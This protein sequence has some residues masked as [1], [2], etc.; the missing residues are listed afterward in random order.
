MDDEKKVEMIHF[1][2]SVGGNKQDSKEKVLFSSKLSD[3]R[4]KVLTANDKR[5]IIQCIG[6]VVT[7]WGNHCVGYGTGTVFKYDRDRNYCY[8]I[9]C[10]HNVVEEDDNKAVKPSGIF[11][12]RIETL[13]DGFKINET[14]QIYD[15]QYH[16]EYLFKDQCHNDIAVLLFSDTDGF[17]QK[18][19]DFSKINL[20]SSDKIPSEFI[21]NYGLYGY[22]FVTNNNVNNTNSTQKT[23]NVSGLVGYLFAQNN[24]NNNSTKQTKIISGQLYGMETKSFFYNKTNNIKMYVEQN[25]NNTMFFYNAIDT[26]GGQ[27]GSSIF[28]S[29]RDRISNCI[30]YGIVGIHTGGSVIKEKNWGVSVNNKKIEWV[31]KIVNDIFKQYTYTHF[32]LNETINIANNLL[33]TCDMKRCD[34]IYIR[35]T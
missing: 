11:F 13:D 12:E 9:T 7:L 2:S 24:N 19:I 14:Y 32:D 26:Q 23:N 4:Q 35:K 16:K 27:S 15:H 6:R 18:N 30:K 1:A 31:N 17:Y 29:F 3:R 10:A 28:L 20:Y 34:Y 22:P 33:R 21:V 25:N 5:V 8:A